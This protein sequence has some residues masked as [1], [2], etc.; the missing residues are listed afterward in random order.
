MIARFVQNI[1]FRRRF[2]ESGP[3]GFAAIKSLAPFRG[4]GVRL[5]I[6]ETGNPRVPSEPGKR[7]WNKL[8]S[9]PLRGGFAPSHLHTIDTRRM[10][11]ITGSHI[12]LH[13]EVQVGPEGLGRVLNAGKYFDMPALQ[14]LEVR[15]NA[16]VTDDGGREFEAANETEAKQLLISM[17]D[18]PGELH[19][20]TEVERLPSGK[21]KGRVYYYS[22]DLWFVDKQGRR[23]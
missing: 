20:V 12:F 4:G 8:H 17:V 6:Y 2:G 9:T 23:L 11:G 21:W 18:V 19:I 7:L 14:L 16:E 15:I 5:T 22:G 1:E 3:S 13:A 10:T